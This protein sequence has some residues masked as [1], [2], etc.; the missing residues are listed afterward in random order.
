[1]VDEF[2]GAEDAENVFDR[3]VEEGMHVQSKLTALHKKKEA[4]F[5]KKHPP[6]WFQ[7]DI[8]DKSSAVKIKRI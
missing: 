8:D 5:L 2:D 6:Q 1:M 7:C 4:K 3:F